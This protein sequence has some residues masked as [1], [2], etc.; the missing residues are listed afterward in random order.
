MT[1]NGPGGIYVAPVHPDRASSQAEW[2][3]IVETT[4]TAERTAGVS[5]D[6]RKRVDDHGFQ[7]IAVIDSEHPLETD[8]RTHQPGVVEAVQPDPGH[9]RD[10]LGQADVRLEACERAHAV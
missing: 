8:R 3:G 2:T 6:G 1:F 7:C 10:V 5:P 9:E 4:S